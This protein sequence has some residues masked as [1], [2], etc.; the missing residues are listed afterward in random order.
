MKETQKW[1]KEQCALS[2]V[3]FRLSKTEQ[4]WGLIDESR[5]TIYT[6]SWRNLLYVLEDVE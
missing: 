2:T 4:D 5:W 3:H 6:K 1:A